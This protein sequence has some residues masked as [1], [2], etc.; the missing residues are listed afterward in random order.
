MSTGIFFFTLSLD[1]EERDD[2]V[3]LN[4]VTFKNYSWFLNIA[5]AANNGT[6]LYVL[7]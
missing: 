4:V 2:K 7:A 3:V 5:F 6:Y 1:A